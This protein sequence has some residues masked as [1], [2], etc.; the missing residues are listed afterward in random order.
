[1]NPDLWGHCG[2]TTI[3]QSVANYSENPNFQM[4]NDYQRWL[5]SLGAVLPCS[6]C[7]QHYYKNLD[8]F[9]LN[10]SLR[11]KTSLLNWVLSMENQVRVSQKKTKHTTKDIKLKYLQSLN[12]QQTQ[13]KIWTFLFYICY[14]FP[15]QPTYDQII[16]YKS[17]FEYMQYVN[18]FPSDIKDRFQNAMKIYPITNYLTNNLLKWMQL[19]Y[20]HCYTGTDNNLRSLK[21]VY[22]VFFVFN[23]NRVNSMNNIVTAVYKPQV[24]ERFG[25]TTNPNAI[26][27]DS[28]LLLLVMLLSVYLLFKLK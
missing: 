11:S 18:I 6:L 2:W 19:V 15:D 10:Q 5:S 7:S 14:G 8:K 21:H 16:Q 23:Q 25:L 13:H 28:N 17:M 9:P 3:Y 26:I 4:I 20:N 22:Q 27:N 1:M 24:V 12:S